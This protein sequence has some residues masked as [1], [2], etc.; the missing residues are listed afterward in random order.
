MNENQIIIEKP[1]REDDGTDAYLKARILFP[2]KEETVFFSVPVQYGDYLAED[3]ADCFV[4][5]AFPWCMKEGYDIVSEAPVSRSIL[6]SLKNR[7]IPGMSRDSKVYSPIGVTAEP[8]DLKYDGREYSGLG[9]SAGVDSFYAYMTHLDAPEG[10]RPTHLLNINAG[11]FEEPA[12]DGKFKRASE[13]NAKDAEKFGLE[14]LSINTDLHIVFPMFYL[15][16]YPSRLASC[17]LALQ[18]KFRSGLISGSVELNRMHYNDEVAG[19]YELIIQNSLSNQNINLSAPGIEVSRA[20]K[21]RRIADF[22]PAQKMLH[23]CVKSEDSNCMTC[24]KCTRVIAVLDALGK[25]DNFGDAFDLDYFR[26][27]YDEIWGQVVYGRNYIHS[28]E[29]LAILKHSGRK[30][31]KKAYMIA[32]MLEAAHKAAESH[33]TEILENNG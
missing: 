2:D 19:F 13:K 21:I 17:M 9:W 18:K 8:S 5:A 29:A 7:V 6:F 11:V 30:P 16:V 1:Y 22:E 27:H 4:A 26:K 31:S 3:L 24:D 10:F 33:R 12:I 15:S 25:I 23:V 14:A 32:R 20:E 28:A